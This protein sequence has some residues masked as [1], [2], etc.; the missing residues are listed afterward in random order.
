MNEE[1]LFK[2]GQRELTPI[3]KKMQIWGYELFD[4]ERSIVDGDEEIAF[5]YVYKNELST[6]T[7]ECI[8]ETIV[9]KGN[10]FLTLEIPILIVERTKE[11]GWEQC[12]WNSEKEEF[13]RS[14]LYE[15]E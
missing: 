3:E 10:S 12:S 4:I 5:L 1:E 14:D 7:F 6:I 13:D 8:S 11:L 2:K 15:N 9:I